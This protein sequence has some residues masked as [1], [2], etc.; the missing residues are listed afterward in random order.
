MDNAESFVGYYVSLT[1]ANESIFEGEVLH[2]DTSKQLI[3]LTHAHELLPNGKAVK[4]PQITIS[5]NHVR[6]LK[7]I[8]ERINVL[9]FT[10]DEKDYTS[11]KNAKSAP[12]LGSIKF[13]SDPPKL[14]TDSKGKKKENDGAGNFPPTNFS[15][16]LILLSP[17]KK[18]SPGYPEDEKHLPSDSSKQKSKSNGNDNSANKSK[19]KICFSE[20]AD[21]LAKYPDFNFEENLARFDKQ[22]IF[23]KMGIDKELSTNVSRCNKK[24]RPQDNI[25]EHEPVSLRQIKV[26]L[27]HAGK[28]YSTEDGF[29]VPAITVALK[30][31]LFSAAEQAGLGLQQ[32]VENAGVCTCQM[33]LQLVGGSLR[34]NPKNDHQRPEFVVLA[35][36]HTQGLQAIC[37]ARH[38]VNH[39]AKV[40]LYLSSPNAFTQSQLDLFLKSGGK[41]ITEYK[42]LPTQ[43][44]DIIIDAMYGMDT[45]QHNADWLPYAVSWAN[46]NKAPL[47]SIDPCMPET[48]SELP[49]RKW[50]IA[51]SLPLINSP[52]VGSIYLADIGI[53]RGVFKDVGIQYMSPFTD[54]YYIPLYNC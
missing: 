21:E 34:I 11:R 48:K 43:P 27:E 41:V 53:P 4:F 18:H 45:S 46:Q 8:R 39:T 47:L 38:L 23:E 29:I 49:D 14:H 13:S 28:E 35:G 1:C 2:I 24:M 6:N 50:C 5:G 36:S 22:A 15:G 19:T 25:L 12:V 9:P 40:I 42:D 54:K 16:D 3:T 44:V 33:A 52:K 20:E 10:K 26:P 17:T 51:M 32:L 31:N 30:L 7:I 37:A